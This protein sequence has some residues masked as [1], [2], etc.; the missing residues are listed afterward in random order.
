MYSLNYGKKF[1]ELSKSNVFIINIAQVWQKVKKCM[2]WGNVLSNL[3]ILE[4]WSLR[5]KL[6]SYLYLTCTL[7]SIYLDPVVIKVRFTLSFCHK[8]VANL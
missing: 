7:K 6:S 3:I 1:M 2:K 4:N 8:Y 5:P